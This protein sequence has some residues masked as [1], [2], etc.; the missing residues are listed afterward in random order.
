M[1]TIIG[2][3]FGP[4]N[5]TDRSVTI[6]GQECDADDM[7]YISAYQLKVKI[8]ALLSQL[9]ILIFKIND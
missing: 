3:N 5:D 4:E 6:G 7:K 9:I 2:K 8:V 1:I